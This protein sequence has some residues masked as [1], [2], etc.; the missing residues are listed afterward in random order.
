MN[1]FTK[2]KQTHRHKNQAGGDQRE[3]GR[4]ETY[5]EFGI[6]RCKALYIGRINYKVL[7]YN[8][9]KYIQHPVINTVMGKNTYVYVYTTESLCCIAKSN[10][11]L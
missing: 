8:T 2:Q 1:I 11:A 4:R 10:T 5:W 6:N 3:A 7:L 9:G